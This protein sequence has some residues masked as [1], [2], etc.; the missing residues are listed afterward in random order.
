[1]V[2]IDDGACDVLSG[3]ASPSHVGHCRKRGAPGDRRKHF[4]VV[5][6]DY[7]DGVIGPRHTNRADNRRKR[8]THDGHRVAFIGRSVEFVC[9]EV[10]RVWIAWTKSHRRVK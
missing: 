8:L 4:S 6:P 9:A 10:N 3:H 2:W 1:M 5:E 7:A